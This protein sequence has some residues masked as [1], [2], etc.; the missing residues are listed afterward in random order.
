[1]KRLQ[2]VGE[3][4]LI[5]RIARRVP[6]ARDVVEGIGDDC[7]VLKLS[8]ATLLVSTDLFVEDVHFRECDCKPHDIGW[9]AAA[10]SL[11]DIAAM[12]GEPRFALVSLSCPPAADLTMMEEMYSGLVDAISQHGAAIVGGDTTRSKNGL[13]IDVAVIGEPVNG[14]YLLRRGAQ[15]N[16][17]LAVTGALGLSA[18]GLH[19]LTHGHKAPTLIKHHFHPVP[20]IPEGQ[21]LASHK[22]VH[23]MLDVSDGLLQDAAHLARASDLGISIDSTA[24]PENPDL[25][26]YASAHGLG[27]NDIILGSGEDY[28]LAFAVDGE[29]ISG[30]VEEFANEFRTPLTVIGTFTDQWTGV[31]VDGHATPT[32]GHDHFSEADLF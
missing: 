19:A 14:R 31:R 25:T 12:G 11:S 20:R 2:D 29:R 27:V 28:E 17:A 3:F 21:W 18:A 24:L 9:K 15:P 22:A 10:S 8:D 4:G 7:A 26:A 5:E 1:V 23:A 6:A 32:Q 30:L 13:V 16:D